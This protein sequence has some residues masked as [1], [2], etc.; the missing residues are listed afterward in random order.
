MKTQ[1]QT[2]ETARPS[3]ELWLYLAGGTLIY[4]LIYPYMK[5]MNPGEEAQTSLIATVLSLAAIY[6]GTRT[7]QTVTLNK[8][9]IPAWWFVLGITVVLCLVAWMLFI[10]QVSFGAGGPFSVIFFGLPFVI[11]SFLFGGLIQL[12]KISARK[13]LD[14]VKI[15][16]AQSNT[17]LEL[18]QSQLSPHFLFNTLNNMYGISMSQH[19]KI[20]ALLLKLSE[21]LRYSLYET[22]DPLV[23]LASEIKYINNYL[24]FERLRMGE[25]LQLKTA[26][27]NMTDHTVLV[28]PMLFIVFIENAVKHAK[29]TVDEK[30]IIDMEL[31]T[32]ADIILFSI[33]NSGNSSELATAKNGGLGLT[34]VRKRLQ[35]LYPGAH[36]LVIDSKQ[37]EFVVTLQVKLRRS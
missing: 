18:L 4:L 3:G 9:R 36:A 2:D 19:E 29:N 17:E 32:F 27:E 30:V 15:S 21:L 11:A 10:S 26:I 1:E 35:L 8:A 33:R 34:N 16:A 12:N 37:N 25:R 31:R 28:A 5:K 20:P 24:D 13:I 23:P 7:C 14:Q 22:R 6:S